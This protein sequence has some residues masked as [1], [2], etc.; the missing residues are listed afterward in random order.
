MS[1]FIAITFTIF[2][3]IDPFGNIPKYLTLLK[4]FD[5]KKRCMIAMREFIFALIIMI[6]FH[7]L[8]RYLLQVLSLSKLT[9]QISAGVILFLVA[10]RMIFPGS[11]EKDHK[12]K[13]AHPFIVPLAT[14]LIASPSVLAI[15][16]IYTQGPYPYYFV[17]AAILCAWFLSSI[18]L[19]FAGPIYKVIGDRGLQA[20]E[21]LMGLIISLIAI[22]VLM[23]GLSSIKAT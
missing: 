19:F 2:F 9:V 6:L 21:K 23:E 20:C 8:G 5:S 13:T 10:I 17:Y 22:Q 18:I 12:W 16:M 7:Y 11:E 1:S 14:P 4:H 3:A 15:I